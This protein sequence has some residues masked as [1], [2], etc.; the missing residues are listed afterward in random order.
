[1]LL[2]PRALAGA[3]LAASALAQ[4]PPVPVPPGDPATP[5]KVVLGKILFWDEQLSSDDSVACGTC[6]RPEAGGADPRA[7]TALHPGPDGVFGT[8]DDVHGAQGMQRQ[9]QNGDFV[10]DPVF[11]L[12]VQ[13]TR[14]SAPS[15]LG[16][17]FH[18]RLFWD[19]RASGRFVDP[20]TGIELLPWGGALESQAA[21][22]ILNRVEMARMGRTWNDVRAKL[23]AV[24]PLALARNLT[25]DVAA[26]LKANPTYPDLFA[27]AFGDAAIDAARI[28]FALASYQRT[29]IPDQTPYDAFVAGDSTALTVQQ[30]LGLLLFETTGRCTSCH[31]EPLFTDD[32]FHDLGLRDMAADTGRGGVTGVPADNGAFKTPSLRNAGLRLRLFHDGQSPPLGSAFDFADPE[33]VASIYLAGGGLDRRNLDPLLLPLGNLGVN[34]ADMALI[35]DFVAHALT[36]PRAALG[37]SPFDHPTLRSD[38]A[39]PATAF[40]APFVGSVEPVLLT[41]V[42]GFVGNVDWKLGAAAGEGPTPAYLA[43]SPHALVPAL[44]AGLLPIYVGPDIRG[45][46]MLLDGPPGRTALGTW[47]IPIPDDPALWNTQVFLQLFAVDAKAWGGVAASSGYAITVQ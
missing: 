32:R 27:D 22:P 1:M 41:P 3:L 39:P 42:P 6:H 7:A 34:G 29:L 2:L 4:M 15:N 5:A 35:L 38:A 26:A 47:H 33:S 45:S 10:L 36:D 46:L 14:R 16:A 20:E 18:A 31:T 9:A 23:Q 28:A 21:A 17:A 12:R 13:V 24:R 25:P 11:D 37:T 30:Q 43:C 40:G 19:G 8:A 44:T